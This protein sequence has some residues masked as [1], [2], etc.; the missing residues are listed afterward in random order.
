LITTRSNAAEEEYF[1]RQESDRRSDDAFDDLKQKLRAE[2]AERD[3]LAASHLKRCPECK[4]LLEKRTLR[5]IDLHQCS[6]CRGIWI[7]PE[8][9][10]HLSKKRR[11]FWERLASWRVGGVSK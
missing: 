9:I 2:Q 1:R 8:E 10:E 7:K 5:G 4:A 11:S 3:R 6:S